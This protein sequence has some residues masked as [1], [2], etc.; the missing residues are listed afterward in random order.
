MAARLMCKA[1][2]RLLLDQQTYQNLSKSVK[3]MLIPGEELIV[4]GSD[5]PLKPYV[6]PPE[7]LLTISD[8]SYDRTES[9]NILKKSLKAKLTVLV[10]QIADANSNSENDIKTVI[11]TLL[12]GGPGTGKSTAMD[13]FRQ[14]IYKRKLPVIYMKHCR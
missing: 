8:G 3:D 11:C 4:K 12:T 10:D 14:S 1:H 13:F 6:F 7:C 2:G 5:I 9:Q